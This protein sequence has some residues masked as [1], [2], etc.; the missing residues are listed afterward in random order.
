MT[1]TGTLSVTV[2][3]RAD[4][5]E[6]ADLIAD[7]FF[8][9]DPSR[10]L[11]A[12][13]AARRR[14]M[15]A[16]FRLFVDY[17]MFKHAG[18]RRDALDGQPFGGGDVYKA[19]VDGRPVG[20][21][22]WLPVV[23]GIPELPTSYDSALEAATGEWVERFR[24]FDIALEAQHPDDHRTPAH[25]HLTMLAVDPAWQGRGVGGAMLRAHHAVLDRPRVP[26]YLEAADLRSR[27][28]YERYGYRRLDEP[29]SLPAGGPLMWPM[30]R[31]PPRQAAVAP[32]R[33]VAR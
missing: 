23:P 32:T 30:W 9:L 27:R 28:L 33:C 31:D 18:S 15:P 11:I 22:I 8:P 26:A 24:D 20:A 13:P 29:I 1:P 5:D 17:G 4:T 21:A 6:L 12:D 14:V 2:A 10:W 16:Y 19:V 7:A 25:A 3:A